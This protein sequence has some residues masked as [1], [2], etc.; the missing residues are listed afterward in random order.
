MALTTPV[1]PGRDLAFSGENWFLY[2]KT[3]YSLWETKLRQRAG[4]GPIFVPIF[5]G[6]HSETGDQN[7]FGEQ[8][9]E[10]DIG[11]IAEIAQRL[12]REVVFLFPLGPLPFL[13]NGGLPPYLARHPALSPWNLSWTLAS[14]DDGVHQLYSFYDPR[15]YKAYRNFAYHFAQYL[16]RKNLRVGIVGIRG[17]CLHQGEFVSYFED[18]GMAYDQGLRRF[19]DMKRDGLPADSQQFTDAIRRE[20]RWREEYV[21]LIQNLYFEGAKE[22]LAPYWQ[23]TKSVCFLGGRP[24]DLPLQSAEFSDYAG[25]YFPMI[26]EC[27][28]QGRVPS[29]LLL[30]GKVLEGVIPRALEGQLSRSYLFEGLDNELSDELSNTSLMPLDLVVIGPHPQGQLAW[31]DSGL[32]PF[33][34]RQYQSCFRLHSSDFPLPLVDQIAEEKITILSSDNSLAA[35]LRGILSGNKVVFDTSTLSVSAQRKLDIFVIENRLQEQNLIWMGTKIKILTLAHGQMVLYSALEQEKIKIEDRELFWEKMFLA[36]GLTHPQVDAPPEVFN[37]WQK[38][39]PSSQ[40]LSFHEMHR[41]SFFNPSSYKKQVKLLSPRNYVMSKVLDPFQAQV[42]NH[43]GSIEIELLP[44][45][46]ISLEYG[47]FE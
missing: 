29:T 30:K 3:S 7:D 43:S 26:Q 25:R 20:I 5:W 19:L 13:P 27:L 9:P 17:G 41:V 32:L 6:L 15:V 11:R 21:T 34:R 45:A 4:Q 39:A 46:S 44:Q 12:N 2:W 23:G 37:F 40:E 22:A 18:R 16:V 47:K 38:R 31:E 10:S 14:G 33:L 8:R 35:G 42:K 36:M 28:Q 24:H 1:M